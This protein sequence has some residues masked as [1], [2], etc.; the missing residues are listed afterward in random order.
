[1]TLVTVDWGPLPQQ[2]GYSGTADLQNAAESL[3]STFENAYYS[4][5]NGSV[6]PGQDTP[7]QVSGHA[8]WEVSYT[9]SYPDASAEG[10]TWNGEM[11]VVVVVDNG[12]GQPGVFF[13]SIPAT[14]NE[15]NIATLISSLRLTAPSAA[16]GTAS[17]TP[18]G[19]SQGGATP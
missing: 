12:T 9:V 13:T 11:A 14:L 18:A 7:V 1:M 6:S 5:L 16:T 19:T 3:A 15:D 2:Y 10:A 8:G 17:A 4:T